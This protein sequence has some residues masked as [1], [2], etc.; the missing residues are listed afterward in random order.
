MPNS[1]FT[2]TTSKLEYQPYNGRLN[3]PL[4]WCAAED[5]AGY[6]YLQ[7]YVPE[8][9]TICAIALQGNGYENGYE[10][11]KDFYLE[12]SADGN[13]WQ[14]VLYQN[15]GYVKVLI[16]FVTLGKTITVAVT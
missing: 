4:S 10:Y 12:Y 8:A 15:T 16:S 5:A 7:I 11:V 3:G 1:S 14:G 2:A 6:E 9:E 13:Q